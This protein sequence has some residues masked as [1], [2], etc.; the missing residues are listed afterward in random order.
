M[1]LISFFGNFATKKSKLKMTY[2][3]QKKKIDKVNR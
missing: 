2:N 3:V 1:K